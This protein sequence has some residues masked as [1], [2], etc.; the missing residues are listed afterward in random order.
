MHLFDPGD[1]VLALAPHTDDVDLGAGGLIVSALARGA[2]VHEVAFSIARESVPPGF[3]PDVLEHEVRRAAEVLGIDRANVTTRDYA[4]RHFPQH[5]QALLEELV[6]LRKKLSPRVVLVP[7]STDVHQDHQTLFEEA[8]R[9]FK[10]TTVLGYELPW[11]H[12]SFSPTAVF[13]MSEAT[14]Q[15]KLRALDCYASQKHRPYATEETVRGIAAMR[16]ATIG[17]RYAEA[18]EVIRLVQA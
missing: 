6:A 18:F 3:P 14:L 13:G 15:T 16:G 10:T 12:L 11:N 7:A 1:V 9:A 17:V 4:V 8:V 2:I 5:R